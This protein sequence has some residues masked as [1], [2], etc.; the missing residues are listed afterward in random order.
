MNRFPLFPLALAALA[1]ACHRSDVLAAEGE[2]SLPAA[3]A[4]ALDF[5][6]DI[7]PLLQRNCYSCHGA[8]HQEGGLRLD[9][10]KRALEGGDGGA[11]IV[12]GKSAESRLVRVIA[13]V[14]EE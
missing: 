14:D 10:K 6:V 12:P 2:R 3:A 7:Q 5:G 8:E 9:L 11:E 4:R 1:L 13:G